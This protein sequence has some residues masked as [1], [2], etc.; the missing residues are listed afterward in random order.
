[1]EDKIVFVEVPSIFPL[2]QTWTK[3]EQFSDRPPVLSKEEAKKAKKQ[4][5]LPE[6]VADYPNLMS[7]EFLIEASLVRSSG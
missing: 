7:V 1:M 5:N 2:P 4:D 6:G 3:F